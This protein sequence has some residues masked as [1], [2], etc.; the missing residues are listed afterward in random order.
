M[1]RSSS[2]DQRQQ[3]AR[4]AALV[5]YATGAPRSGAPA[6]GGRVG[7]PGRLARGAPQGGGAGRAAAPDSSDPPARHPVASWAR[8]AG[9]LQG[10]RAEH[11]VDRKARCGRAGFL[12]ELDD[13]QAPAGRPPPPARPLAA[14]T[15]APAAPRPQRARGQPGQQRLIRERPHA[16]PAPGGCEAVGLPGTPRHRRRDGR[17]LAN[18]MRCGAGDGAV[19]QVEDPRHTTGWPGFG[20]ADLGTTDVGRY[21]ATGRPA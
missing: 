14:A 8:T 3:A 10:P 1:A 2:S 12:G 21:R 13:P 6:P 19:G 16:D 11:G 15:G 9:P 17:L 7:E 4:S 20:L 5:A 18:P